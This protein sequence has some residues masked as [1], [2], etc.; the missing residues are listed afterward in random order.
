MKNDIICGNEDTCS[1]YD[2]DDGDE[3]VVNLNHNI[4]IYSFMFSLC[5]DI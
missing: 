1:D 4:Y 3:N 2:F 5:K